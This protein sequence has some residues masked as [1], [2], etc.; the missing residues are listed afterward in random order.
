MAS[1]TEW[2][3]FLVLSKPPMLVI[4]HLLTH[5]NQISAFLHMIAYQLDLELSQVCSKVWRLV[6]R[7]SRS[8][9]SHLLLLPC[10]TGFYSV[11]FRQST[12]VLLLL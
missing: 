7:A 12:Q 4:H 9:Q 6:H 1:A 8:F 5:V 2:V 10:S 11:K 3:A